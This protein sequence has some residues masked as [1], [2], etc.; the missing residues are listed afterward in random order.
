[1][2]L[3][4]KKKLIFRKPVDE[5]VTEEELEEILEKDEPSAY[6]GYAPTGEM[7]IGHFTTVRKIAD[8]L[9]AGFKFKVLVAD[10]H[11]ELDVEKTPKELLYART[12]WYT[13]A[14]KGMIEAAGAELDKVE[15]VKGSD[16]QHEKDYQKGYMHLMENATV[17]RAQRA[18][19]E[20]VRHEESIKASGVLYPFMQIMDCVAL[21]VDIAYSGTD[22]R[23]IYMLGRETLPKVGEE[24][25]T[26][27]FSEMLPGLEGGKMSSSEKG[28]KVAV[29]DSPEV[30]KERIE[31][32]YCPEG[33]V[34]GNT[35]LQY[36]DNLLFPLLHDRDEKFHI[37][38]PKK[39]GGNVEYSNYRGLEEDFERGDLHPQDLKL[40]LAE[41][42]AEILK[43]VRDRFEGKKGLAEKAFPDE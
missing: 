6:I 31:N 33:K 9:R 4:E 37:E 26:C 22:Q 28:S 17:N 32:A 5:V 39:Y 42:L 3:E 12:E 24:K 14:M 8:F 20:V 34:E 7:H 30:I 1:M 16:F 40:A 38:R 43:P 18:S 25:I 27:V 21:D 15:I 19:S 10:I 41:K 23:R 13:E 35:V 36:V 11:A 2:D 29:T